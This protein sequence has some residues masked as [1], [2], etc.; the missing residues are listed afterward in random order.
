M[1]DGCAPVAI[2]GMSCRFPGASNPDEFWRLLVERRDGVGDYPKG[3][4]SAMDTFYASVGKDGGPKTKRSGTLPHLKEFDAAFFGI[5]P[6]EAAVIDPQQRLLLELSWEAFEDAGILRREY[7]GSDTGVYA[8]SWLLDYSS[9]MHGE[10]GATVL[11]QNGGGQYS[12]SGRLSYVFDLRGPDA[13]INLGCASGLAAVHLACEGLRAGECGMALAGGAN[14]IL[15]PDATLAFTNGGVLSPDGRCKFGD[16]GADGFVRSEGAG[17]FL[18][19]LLSRAVEDGD[20]VH[21]VIR[22]SALVN[23]GAS[24]GS[25]T[26]P[27]RIAQAE[28]LQKACRSAGISPAQLDYVEAHGTG[29]AVGDPVEIGALSEVVGRAPGR[30]TPCVI[31][32]AKTNIGHT[33]SASGIAGMIKTVL[34]MRHKYIPVSLHVSEL[35]PKIDWVMSGLRL[36]TAGSDWP[37]ADRPKLAGV[38]SF[39]LTGTNAHLILE[40]APEVEWTRPELKAWVLPITAHSDE[41]LRELAGSWAERLR[42]SD[43]LAELCTT[44]ATRRTPLEHRLCVTG[45]DAG[46]LASSIE[47]WLRGEGPVAAHHGVVKDETKQFVFVFPGQGAQ[48]A[49]MG[50]ELFRS[51]RVFRETLEACNAAIH[52]ETKWSVIERLFSEQAASEL[53]DVAFVQP[54]LFAIQVALARLWESWGMIADVVV[55][56]SMG[57]VAA[58]HI[59][60]ALSLADAAAVICRRSRLLKRVSGQGAMAL[61]ELSMREAEHTV[62]EADGRI[63]IAVSNGER[64]TVVSGGFIDVMELVTRLEREGVFCRVIKVDVASHGP[65]MDPLLEELENALKD[66]RPRRAAVPIFSTVLGRRITGEEMDAAYWARNLRDPVLF[67]PAVKDLLAQGAGMF[68]E[69]SPHPTLSSYVEAAA[70]SSAVALNSLRRDEPELGSMFEPLSGLFVRGVPVDWRAIYP[71]A[72]PVDLPPFPWQRETFWLEEASATPAYREVTIHG[73]LGEVSVDAAG[74]SAWTN[75][76]LASLPWLRDHVVGASVLIPASLYMA[77]ALEAAR[78]LTGAGLFQVKRLF[79]REAVFVSINAAVQIETLLE[80]E[81]LGEHAVRFYVRT[82]AEQSASA[83]TLAATGSIAVSALSEPTRKEVQAIDAARFMQPVRAGKTVNLRQHREEMAGRGYNFGPSFLCLDSYVLEESDAIG[84]ATLPAGID[85]AKGGL[86]A[87]LLDA[88][89]QLLAALC[90]ARGSWPGQL[91]PVRLGSIEMFESVSPVDAVMIRAL[92]PNAARSRGDLLFYSETGKLVVKVTGVLFKSVERDQSSALL[93][94][95]YG[96]EWDAAQVARRKQVDTIRK[97]VILADSSDRGTALDGAL[98]KHGTRVEL[99]ASGLTPIDEKEKLLLKLRTERNGAAIGVVD[100]RGCDLAS[101][102]RAEDAATYCAQIAEV[103][104][105]LTE[106]G[107]DARL[108][109]V[110]RSAEAIQG[111]AGAVSIAQGAI[112]GLAAVIANEHPELQCVSIDLSSNQNG[113]EIE[114]LADELLSIEAEGRIALRGETRWLARL[115]PMA[116]EVFEATASAVESATYRLEQGTTGHVDSLRLVEL[117]RKA[118]EDSEIE[119]Q[120]EAAGLSFRDVMQAMGLFEDPSGDTFGMGFEAAGIVTRVGAGVTAHKVGDTVMAVSSGALGNTLFASHAIVSAELAV[121]R[122]GGLGAA[123]AAALPGAYLTAYYGLVRLANLRKGERVLIHAAAGGVGLAA[124]QVAKFVGAEIFATA[125]SEEKSEYLR[126]LGIVHVMDSRNSGFG[127][128]IDRATGGTG[129]DVVLNSLAGD[130]VKEGM[131]ALAA[132]GRF[133]EIGKRDM[134]RDSSVGMSAFMRNRSFMGLDLATMIE[135]RPVLVAALLREI[136]GLVEDGSLAALPVKAFGASQAAEAFRFMAEARQIGK[137][138]LDMS[139]PAIRVD[140]AHEAVK[141]N[142][143]Y[144]ITGGIGGLGIESAKEL[145][146]LGARNLVL[147]SRSQASEIALEEIA[148]LRLKG[149]DVRTHRIDVS[150]EKELRGVIGEIKETMPALRGVV[151]AAGVLDDATIQ[152]L[153]RAKFDAAMSGKVSGALLLD[154]LTSD[155]PLDFFVLYS[156]VASLLGSP[157]QGNYAAANSMLDAL[158]HDRRRRG[159]RATS[160]SWG[161]WSDLGLAAKENKR[162]ARLQDRG[163]PSISPLEGRMLLRQLLRNSQEL[164]STVVFARVNREEWLAHAPAAGASSFLSLLPR[165]QAYAQTETS[166]NTVQGAEHF[167]ERLRIMDAEA[168]HKALLDHLREQT[169]MVVRMKPMQVAF[170]KPFKSFGVDSLMGVELRQ[171][172]EKSLGLRLSSSVV[173]N[174]PTIA[175]LG[176]HLAQRLDIGK[177]SAARPPAEIEWHDAEIEAIEEDGAELDALAMLSLEIMEAEDLLGRT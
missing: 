165:E 168:G 93:G 115:K 98:R 25:I 73:L 122:P 97:W 47:E 144:L 20:R 22:G 176:E 163:L 50:R 95:V 42:R 58:A 171:R 119:I 14:A 155:T 88:G 138:V 167:G 103:V 102:A 79:V 23:S 64:A 130:A 82:G 131:D 4:S 151:H 112:S 81:S 118:P 170:D 48:W 13:A 72:E 66:V 6:R 94:M 1:T 39:G 126:R 173:W 145:V 3:R 34:A 160:I 156:S 2:I 174:Y 30:T 143:T 31:G 136:A 68:L 76:G 32:S 105:L 38:S 53:N 175:E 55:G 104:R 169:A 153:D 135:D 75:A 10:D 33:E 24:S 17:V 139:D 29:T 133:V 43:E 52:Q 101:E 146:E 158:A 177:R 161:P 26:T 128:Y 59:A 67:Y 172:L 91:L 69:M 74:N 62:S 113:A 77:M 164:P 154:R 140:L 141:K 124:V 150:D 121:R 134:W 100:L 57:E 137:V 166:R 80:A 60:G 109:V 54:A 5:S 142:A 123:E 149:A 85:R 7:A 89:L 56:H 99:V 65:Q 70:G 111:D 28:V 162:G 46:A 18:L 120:V 19:K 36:E 129:V 63:S 108:A 71:M 16:A 11:G 148:A 49:G 15:D 132:Y 107:M 21:A 83:W 35:N 45:K 157:G 159:H 8:G 117:E 9:L 116:S 90:Y 12:T 27:S 127:G 125:G 106:T 96:L 110:T 92:L 44:S 41:A 114:C 87:V 86:H 37:K 51:Q 61:L 147:I 84:R 152:N 78:H 40:E